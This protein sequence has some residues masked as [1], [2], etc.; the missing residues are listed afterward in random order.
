MELWIRKRHCIRDVWLGHY[1]IQNELGSGTFGTVFA[2]WDLHLER[3]VALKVLK[4]NVFESRDTLLTEAR[5][6]A[7]INHSNVCAIYAV[8]A[9]DGLPVIAMEHV[10]GQS[11]ASGIS[12][13]VDAAAGK[14]LAVGIASGLVAAH[15][16][17]V[18]HG[19]LK[20]ANVIVASDGTPKIVDFGLATSSLASSKIQADADSDATAVFS[21]S[22]TNNIRGTPAYM[23]PEQ[24]IGTEPTQASD[25]FSFGLILFEIFTRRRAI[26]DESLSKVFERLA[27][28][29]LGEQLAPQVPSDY[30]KL[31]IRMLA[32]EPES[33]P[34]MSQVLERLGEVQD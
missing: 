25:V 14:R 2:A 4:Q 7:K 22:G 13:G 5:A 28:K 33:R 17:Q 12:D 29:N 26:A 8:E 31:L 30:S 9:E 23:A 1:R 21:D 24:A 34:T 18:V 15:E 10:D 27:A 3:T 19:D 16:K 32:H 20:P 11:L 6:A